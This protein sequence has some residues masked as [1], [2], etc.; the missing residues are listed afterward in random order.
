M[1]DHLKQEIEKEAGIEL[2]DDWLKDFPAYINHL[3]DKDFEKLVFILYRID[4][5]EDLIK[6]LLLHR[7]NENAGELIADA[8]IKRQLQKVETR[9]KYKETST[10]IP[11]DEKW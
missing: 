2:K 11:D 4:V 10:D 1:Q 8:I 7:G 6:E 9:E 5:D 3:I